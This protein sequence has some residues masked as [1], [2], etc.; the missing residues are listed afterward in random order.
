MAR[1]VLPPIW[2]PTCCAI[3]VRFRLRDTK[4]GTG[5]H[6][7]LRPGFVGPATIAAVAELLRAGNYFRFMMHVADDPPRTEI[8]GE[9]D[10]ATAILGQAAAV[11]SSSQIHR[12]TKQTLPL[13]RLNDELGLVQLNQLYKTWKTLNGCL[14]QDVFAHLDQ[15][16]LGRSMLA[17]MADNSA[18]VVQFGH[19]YQNID[20]D[21]CDNAIGRPLQDLPDRQYG[22]W[23]AM[24]MTASHESRMPQLELVE[25]DLERVGLAP[26]RVRYERLM[27]PWRDGDV[28]FVGSASSLR[29]SFSTR[30]EM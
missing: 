23:I 26:V 24:S 16:T 22:E 5:V 27:L 28:A 18:V 20:A 12:F 14:T 21:W 3:S 8:V 17:R 13:D 7:S 15:M 9:L 30:L 6:V 4:S 1:S 11:Q 10:D 2:S 25:A 29:G 19:G